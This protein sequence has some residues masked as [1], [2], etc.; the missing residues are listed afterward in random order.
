MGKGCKIFRSSNGT[1]D[2]IEAPNGERSILFDSINERVSNKE[3]AADIWAVSRTPK[4][5]NEVLEPIHSRHKAQIT[6]SIRRITNSES[7]FKLIK[8]PGMKTIQL[9]SEDGGVLGR[10]RFKEKGENT[11]QVDSS[12]VQATEQGK[13]YGTQLYLGLAQYALREGKNVESSHKLSPGSNGVWNKLVTEGLAYK[14]NEGE[15]Q[16]LYRLNLFPKEVDKNGEVHMSKILS[17]LDNNSILEKNYGEGFSV[18]NMTDADKA[19]LKEV[20][21]GLS[22]NSSE[23]LLGRLKTAFL[24]EGYFRPTRESLRSSG[25]YNSTEITSILIDEEMQTQIRGF[26]YT[27][28]N[29]NG[30]VQNDVYVNKTFLRIK[31]GK[32]NGIGKF[33]LENPYKVEKE[34]LDI[35]GGI[36]TREEFEDIL[37]Q[38]ERLEYLRSTY[39]ET[40]NTKEDLFSKFSKFMRVAELQYK[41]GVLSAKTSN[42]REV[43]EEVI[44]LPE[45]K[46]LIKSIEILL[47]LNPEIFRR[48]PKDIQVLNKRVATELIN[49][50]ID[51]TTFINTTQGKTIE[52]YKQFLKAVQKFIV[53]ENDS[54]LDS[55]AEEYDKYFKVDTSYKFKTKLVNENQKG[56]KVYHLNNPKSKLEVFTN[57]GL[58]PVGVN[59]YRRADR[60]ISLDE[61]YENLY[62]SITQNGYTNILNE[63]AFKP[64]GYNSKG[65]LDIHKVI[66]YKN[67]E[68]IMRD[69]KAYLQNQVRE[70]LDLENNLNKEDAEKYVLMFNY[71]NK[72]NKLNKFEQVPNIAQEL[73]NFNKEISNENFLKTE[74]ISK[75]Y[76]DGLKAKLNN[77]LAYEEFYSNFTVD[78][79]GIS[80][81]NTDPITLSRIQTYLSSQEDL[82]NYMRLHKQGVS[83]EETTEGEIIQDDLFMR[84]FITNFPTSIKVLKGD[85]TKLSNDTILTESKEPFIRI[86]E[87]VYELISGVG[88]RGVY[89]KLKVSEGHYK[90]YSR[91]LAPPE[92][93]IDMSEISAI[94]TNEEAKIEVN[95][96]YNKEEEEIINNQ[97]DNC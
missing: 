32:R 90:E 51:A 45:S 52:E 3:E 55:L 17:F 47:R 71:F 67:K 95:N 92:L 56:A 26:I 82:L 97:H 1:V 12:L 35:L 18:R 83:F 22:V 40:K 68:N 62:N 6:E 43:M 88:S 60:E 77:K 29:M 64:S 24:P 66:D 15:G 2:Y 58:V 31:D 11:I 49:M 53:L 25:L 73:N 13:G 61:L 46:N 10:I 69:M 28:N 80:L 63:E 96:L 84:N 94:E 36:E 42:T 86:S 9:K 21:L 48:N 85:Y 75:F 8:T 27:F 23:E 30:E 81:E 57:T 50:G 37:F 91:E 7:K 76:K 70:V 38:D 44:S 16:P 20:M 72:S 41:D 33:V 5:V 4:F 59:L 79:T 19:T 54:A 39:I 78:N 87:G 93:D 65:E 14:T 34:A 74:F 89:G